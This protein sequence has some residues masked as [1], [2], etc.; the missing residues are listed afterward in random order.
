MSIRRALAA[1][2]L[3]PASLLAQDTARGVR[4]GLTYDPGSRPGIVVLPGKGVGADSI[5]SIIQRDLDYGDRVN[6]IV[7]DAAASTAAERASA[8]NWAVFGRLG[9]AA[10]VQVTPTPAGLHLAVYDIAK[11]TT[12]LVR[13]YPAPPMSD[14]R[15]WRAAVHGLSDELEE[16]LTGTRGIA[17]SRVLFERGRRLWVVDSDGEQLRPVTDMEAKAP[18]W[19][20][21]GTMIAFSTVIPSSI[22]VHDL[23]SGRTR[24]FASGS[25]L[26][27]SP[28]FSPDGASVVYGHGVDDGVD[29]FTAP[30]SGGSGRRL[31]VGRGSDNVSPSFSP[32][33]SRIAFMSGR[34]G[35]P[36]IYTMDA[37]GTNVDILTPLDF[38]EAAH[39]GNPSWSPDGRSVAFYS[40][41]ARRFQLMTI[42]LRDRGLKQL[43]SDGENEDPSWAPD[44][45]HLV[46]VSNRGGSDQLWILDTETGRSRQLTRGARVQSPAWSPRL[47]SN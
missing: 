9:A 44:G 3:A 45:R 41:I 19:H 30:L 26:F 11:Q 1:L 32:D 38:G 27:T 5:R 43:T 23:V 42:S 8:P 6:V 36:E 35:H 46:F 39:R 13:D 17:R 18:S 12:A 34:A 16:A 10:A 37:D 25:G 7:L 24:T 40:S 28:V 20:P 2:L 15:G 22:V 33:G 14:M 29:I 31:S 47:T 21:S 4:I